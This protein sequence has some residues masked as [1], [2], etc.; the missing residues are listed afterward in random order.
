MNLSTAL[1]KKKEPDSLHLPFF[2]WEDFGL[3]FAI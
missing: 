1:V 3:G 2:E